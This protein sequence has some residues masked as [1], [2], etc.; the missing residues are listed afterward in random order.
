MPPA[1][2]LTI[3]QVVQAFFSMVPPGIEPDSPTCLMADRRANSAG[4]IVCMLTPLGASSVPGVGVEPT[5]FCSSGR[6]YYRLSYPGSSANPVARAPEFRPTA[7]R[8]GIEPL[9]PD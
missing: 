5:A 8:R 7:V 6:R 3:A 2:Q 1:I 9:F 4:Q